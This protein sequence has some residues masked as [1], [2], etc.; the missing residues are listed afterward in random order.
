MP[1]PDYSRKVHCILGL[2]FDA[3]SQTEAEDIVRDAASTGRRCFIS[4]PNLNFAMA[5]RTD[6]Q[7]RESVIRSD[8]SIADGMPIVGIGRLL[9]ATLPERVSGSTL[10]ERLM[11]GSPA[12]P[13]K[14]FL[15][16]GEEGVA[17]RAAEVLAPGKTGV[18]CVGFDS[19]GFGTIED[20]SRPA[21]IAKINASGAHFLM[22]SV[23]ARKG[24]AWLLRNLGLLQVPVLAYL[25]A[26]INFVAGTV[27]RAPPW[28]Q[29]VHLEWFWRLLQEPSLWRRYGTDGL[30][31]LRVLV[32]HALP[33]AVA[34]RIKAPS[35]EHLAS[36]NLIV[37]DHPNGTVLR[38]EGAWTSHN[39][40]PLRDA[41]IAVQLARSLA[42]DVDLSRTTYIDTAVVGLLVLATAAQPV[43][44]MGASPIARRVLIWTGAD[45]L[46]Q[47]PRDAETNG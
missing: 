20:M 25:G 22:V 18:T 14:V 47:G 35:R 24:Q 33:A 37:S 4:T 42:L 15:F 36:A 21:V 45:Y 30:A 3:V 40:D 6:P 28:M 7:F 26:V 2:P 17:A 19:P 12:R 31:L 38:L 32:R 41:L 39:L 5:C 23:G 34:L 13:L 8:L 46:L 9:G 10:F 44:V 16:G 43:R 11:L 27:R 29:R 1:A